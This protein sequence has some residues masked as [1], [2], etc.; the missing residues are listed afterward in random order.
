MLMLVRRRIAVAA[1]VCV[2]VCAGGA[3]AA[4]PQGFQSDAEFAASY[5]SRSVTSVPATTQRVSCYTPQVLYQGSLS[6]SQGYPDGGA[7]P[8]AGAATTGELLG[9]FATQDVSNP[10]LRAKD[11]SESVLHVDPTSPRHVIGVS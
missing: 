6:P 11:F 4:P 8:C 5:A 2:G 3:T 7:T 1:A 9:P 10:P